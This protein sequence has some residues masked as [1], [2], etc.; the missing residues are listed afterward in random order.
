[1][2]LSHGNRAYLLI[3]S[4]CLPAALE[5][6]GLQCLLPEK[7]YSWLLPWVLGNSRMLARSLKQASGAGDANSA[8]TSPQ[9]S[10]KI[11]E[12]KIVQF[13]QWIKGRQFSLLT[14]SKF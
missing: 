6:A 12:K 13:G 9:V 2:H 10:H 3:F 11:G 7:L 4:S 5:T 8:P 14:Y 1:M